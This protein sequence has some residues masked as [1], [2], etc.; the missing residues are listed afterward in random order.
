MI[1][2]APLW[3]F[4]GYIGNRNDAILFIFLADFITGGTAFGGQRFEEAAFHDEMEIVEPEEVKEKVQDSDK[5]T[6]PAKKVV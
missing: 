5:E 2:F 6:K 3:A 4:L 1:K